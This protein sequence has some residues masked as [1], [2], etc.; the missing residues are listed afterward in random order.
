MNRREV[1][2]ALK[3]YFDIRELVCPHTYAAFGE[4]SWQFYDFMELQVIYILRYEIFP[5]GMIINTYKN[6]GQY[7]QRGNRCNICS[8]VKEKTLAGQIYLTAHKGMGI[9]FDVPGLTAEQSRQR[10]FV[11]QDKLPCRIRLEKDV[12]WVHQDIY[13]DINSTAKII[14]F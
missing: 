1:I 4:R 11:K 6:G 8:L 10:I 9:D 3:K 5:E 7:S 13:D 2:I 14:L 12:N